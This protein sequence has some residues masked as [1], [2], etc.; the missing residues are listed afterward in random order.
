MEL[1]KEIGDKEIEETIN[2]CGETKSP[3]LDGFNFMFLK[4]NWDTLKDDFNQAVRW[5]LRERKIPKGCN[6][7]FVTSLRNITNI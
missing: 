7:S 1:T 5:F 2:Q 3:G 6:A 4:Y